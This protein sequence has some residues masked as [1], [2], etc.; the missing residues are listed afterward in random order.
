MLNVRSI[1]E[2]RYPRFFEEHQTTAQTLCRFLGFLF[3]EKRFQQFE[4]EFPHL[5]G[6]DF[7]EEVLRYFDFNL[8]LQEKERSRI[9]D[10]GRLV[11]VAN[12]PIGSLDGLALLDL[13]REVRP[14][15]RV[16][17]NEVLS[18]IKPLQ[19]LLLPVHNMG[20]NTPKENL[21]NIRRYLEDEGALIIFPGGRG[22]APGPERGKRWGM[23][24]RLCED[25]KGCKGTY[26]ARLRSRPQFTVLLQHIIPGQTA[27]HTVAGSGDVQAES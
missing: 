12:H 18:E 6:F 1:L 14:D 17:A 9:P 2:Q 25:C 11:I 13:V 24:K 16:V 7:V 3:Y 26:S 15:V 21:R 19:R 10:S 22:V 23:A 20:G 5:K 8:R 4:R 27:V